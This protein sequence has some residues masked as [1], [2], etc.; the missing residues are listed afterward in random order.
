[1]PNQCLVPDDPPSLF[2]AMP[3]RASTYAI[4]R[5]HCGVG[6]DALDARAADEK[7]ADLPIDVQHVGTRLS[8]STGQLVGSD[9]ITAAA[10]RSCP[11]PRFTVA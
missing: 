2:L 3:T 6:P 11:I 8:C 5:F 4:I 1:M 7:Q 9:A 10:A